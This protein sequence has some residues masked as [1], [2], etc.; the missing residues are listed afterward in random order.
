M[1]KIPPEIPPLNCAL[2]VRSEDGAAVGVTAALVVVVTMMKLLILSAEDEVAGEVCR[3][4]DCKD[5]VIDVCTTDRGTESEEL[6]ITAVPVFSDVGI[7]V[8]TIAVGK[9]FEEM[10][11]AAVRVLSDIGEFL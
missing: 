1:P 5:I 6:I 7:D 3:G 10:V 2:W 8:S 9:E 4:M 11:A